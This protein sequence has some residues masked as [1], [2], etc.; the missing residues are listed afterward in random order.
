M[1]YIQTMTLLLH[2]KMLVIISIC[3]NNSIHNILHP[4]LDTLDPRILIFHYFIV[5]G[6]KGKMSS[7]FHKTFWRTMKTPFNK[8]C[9][10]SMI[11]FSWKIFLFFFFVLNAFYFS[12]LRPL[13]NLYFFPRGL[14]WIF[15]FL[16]H[17]ILSNDLK[18]CK[19]VRTIIIFNRFDNCLR[20]NFIFKL[21]IKSY[22]I[23]SIKNRY[24]F[25]LPIKL[26]IAVFNHYHI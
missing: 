13:M 9:F 20:I 25:I 8:S 23:K 3:F 26:I 6:L 18:H 15:V 11:S 16:D 4:I 5:R 14:G 2:T 22:L 24:N 7:F 12:R 21:L 1:L 17:L 19:W 10:S